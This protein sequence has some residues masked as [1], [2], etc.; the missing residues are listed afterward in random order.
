MIATNEL[1]LV[2]GSRET[3]Y[4]PLVDPSGS[5]E[6]L[7]PYDGASMGVVRSQN[8]STLVL[9]LRTDNST[10]VLNHQQ[11]RLEF[12]LS[13]EASDALPAGVFLAQIGLRRGD[14]TSWEFSLP[15]HLRVLPRFA[16]RF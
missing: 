15:F 3:V 10:L 4:I 12:A 6:N 14:A 2:A 13:A 1:V 16:P 8:D 11:S 9:S 5:P 7:A